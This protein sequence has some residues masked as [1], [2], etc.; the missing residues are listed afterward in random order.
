L[1]AEFE[2]SGLSQVSFCQSRGLSRA[3]LAR[4]R[5]RLRGVG[6]E[7]VEGSRWVAVEVSGSGVGNG[8][9]SG[10]VLAVGGG[11]RI[12]VGRGFDPP[13]LVQLLSVLERR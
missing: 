3:T 8:G 10:L 5:K 13:T 12:E 7:I 4:C 2:A 9:D 6:S 1:V 11:R